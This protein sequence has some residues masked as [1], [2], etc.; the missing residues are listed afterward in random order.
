MHV[1]VRGQHMCPDGIK[2]EEGGTTLALFARLARSIVSNMLHNLSVCQIY[3]YIIYV[4]T[5]GE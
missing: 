1:R 2:Q 4:Y 3:I 5:F